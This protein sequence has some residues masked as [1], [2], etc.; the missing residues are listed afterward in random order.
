MLCIL[1]ALC[2]SLV[3]PLYGATGTHT[4]ID[5]EIVLVADGPPILVDGF[6]P[7]F[8]QRQPRENGMP[9]DDE[10]MD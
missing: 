3:A 9:P 8:R 4:P 5:P 1:L 7:W 2:C 6:R 10:R